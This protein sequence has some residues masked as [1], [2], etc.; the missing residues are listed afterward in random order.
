MEGNGGGDI[1]IMGL[2]CNEEN[3]EHPITTTGL[4][5]DIW[6]QDLKYT[7]RWEATIIRLKIK[8]YGVY[9][10]RMTI[11]GAAERRTGPPSR[12]RLSMR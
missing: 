4:L 7:K 10:Y 2:H 3:H 12:R 11:L 5:V 1:I 8:P 6:T 9:T